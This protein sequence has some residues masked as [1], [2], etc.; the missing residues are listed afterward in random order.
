[1]ILQFMGP[2]TRA[3]VAGP[4]APDFPQATVRVSDS[5]QGCGVIWR[6]GGGPNS[7]GCWQ[8]S[9]PLEPLHWGLSFF[10]AVGQRLPLAPSY[11]DRS[12]KHPT[13][14][15]PETVQRASEKAKADRQR[16]RGGEGGE[17]PTS[18]DG[19]D[20]A[21]CL[22]EEVTSLHLCHI[23]FVKRSCNFFPYSRG[24][25]HTKARILGG[26]DHFGDLRSLPSTTTNPLFSFEVS[27]IGVYLQ[28]MSKWLAPLPASSH[29]Y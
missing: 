22:A 29:S 17:I 10:W 19:S 4:F 25:D 6:L 26:G 28:Q 23:L 21:V 15:Q 12:V 14:W 13:A 18:R 1:M 16:E 20:S 24:G 27:E 11:G 5:L 3:E 9:V 2:G 7:P 8:D